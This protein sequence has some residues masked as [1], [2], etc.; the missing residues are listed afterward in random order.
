MW[1][2]QR[3]NYFFVNLIMKRVL[4]LLSCVFVIGIVS[5]CSGK[6]NAISYK[7]PCVSANGGPCERY[8]VNDWWLKGEKEPRLV[9]TLV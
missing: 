1:K 5:G 3:S 7:S 8:S 2:E 9:R 6:T 4:L